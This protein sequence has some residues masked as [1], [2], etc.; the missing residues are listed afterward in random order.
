M[1]KLPTTPERRSKAA[2]YREAALLGEMG[3]KDGS[4]LWIASVDRGFWVG[5]GLV[6]RYAEIFGNGSDGYWGNLWADL[7]PWDHTSSGGETARNCRVLALCFMAAM[8]EAGDA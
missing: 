4:C 1:S 5:N 6:E 3:A 8:V 2:I 7:H